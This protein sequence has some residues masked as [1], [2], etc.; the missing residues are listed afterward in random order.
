MPRALVVLLCLIAA[1]CH[2]PE[3]ERIRATS[4][5]KYDPKTGRLVEIT[6][7][8]NKNGVIDTWVSMDGIRPVSARIDSDEDGKMDRWEYYDASGKLIRVGESR[9]KSGRPDLWAY[10]AADGKPER[11]EFLEVSNVT[12]REGIVR[13]EIYQGGAKVRGE[14]DTDGDGVMDRWETFEGGRL[15]T[16]EF[17]DSKKRDGKP[18]QR[19]TY[20]NAGG[21]VSIETGPDGNGGY[22]QKREIKR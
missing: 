15:K 18:T 22:R 4:Q 16:V 8:K 1:A 13:R 19:F 6:Y 11:I 17:D 5:G 3:R 20:D 9:A 7:D 2:D 10:L 14:E 21:L 12:N